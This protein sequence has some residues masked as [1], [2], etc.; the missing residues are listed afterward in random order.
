MILKRTV[1]YPKDIQ[2][3]TGKSE[4]TGRRLLEKIRERRGKEK[5]QMITVSEFADYTGIDAET[6]Q[7][8]L[9]D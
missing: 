4:R 8:Y 9:T 3:I 1:I 5:H 6:V 2:R 7:E